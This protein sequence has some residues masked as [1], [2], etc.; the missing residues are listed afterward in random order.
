M[1]KYNLP[2]LD[3]KNIAA[4]ST[5][6]RVKDHIDLWIEKYIDEA[7]WEIHEHEPFNDKASE[8]NV[9]KAMQEL[10]A[11]LAENSNM[12]PTFQESGLRK[13]RMTISTLYFRNGYGK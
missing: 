9:K 8:Y 7:H 3:L 2:L 11:H 1:S 12:Y 4:F 10:G 13:R 6:R 5:D